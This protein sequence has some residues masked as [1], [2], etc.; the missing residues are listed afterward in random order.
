MY[1]K[2]TKIINDWD[3]VGLH[4]VGLNEYDLEVKEILKFLEIN[5]H[6]SKSDLADAINKI[7]LEWF[8]DDVYSVKTEDAKIVAQ[9]IL[10]LFDKNDKR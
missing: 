2:I 4:M 10:D 9:D 7:F 3:P 5:R 8:G 6:V 1:E